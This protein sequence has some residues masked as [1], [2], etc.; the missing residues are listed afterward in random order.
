MKEI[1]LSVA[2]FTNDNNIKNEILKS[3]YVRNETLKKCYEISGYKN[4]SLNEKN[5]IYDTLKIQVLNQ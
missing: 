1:I 4:L 5:K 3:D 2:H